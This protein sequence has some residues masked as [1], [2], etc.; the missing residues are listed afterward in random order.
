MWHLFMGDFSS[1]VVPVMIFAIPIVAIIGGITAGVVKTISE[2]RIVENAQRERIA[3]IQAGIDPSKL[4]PLPARPTTDAE[5]GAVAAAYSGASIASTDYL[6][7]RRAN[8]LLIGGLVVLCAGIGL[9]LFL[10]YIGGEEGNA[11]A[12]GLIPGF[13]GIGLLLSWFVTRPRDSK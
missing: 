4:P 9:S 11:W 13:V 5:A 10:Y 3:A 12:V 2:G 8:S 6:L 1:L 7:R